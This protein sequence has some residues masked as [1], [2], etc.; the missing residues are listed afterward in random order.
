MR[1]ITTRDT[2]SRGIAT[3]GITTRWITMH[4]IAMHDTTRDVYHGYLMISHGAT[5]GHACKNEV[6]IK[7]HCL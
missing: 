3:R 1:G 5:H 4:G 6:V 2:T 7:W